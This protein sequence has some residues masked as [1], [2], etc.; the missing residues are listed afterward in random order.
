LQDGLSLQSEQNK[1]NVDLYIVVA[2]AAAGLLFATVVLLLLL[3]LLNGALFQKFESK[4]M[5]GCT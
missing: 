2:A 1:T 5:D 4:T 3:L